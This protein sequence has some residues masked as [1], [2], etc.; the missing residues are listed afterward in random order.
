M[1]G[2]TGGIR[3]TR[4][5]PNGRAATTPMASSVP[6]PEAIVVTHWFDPGQDGEPYS[7]TIQL[8]GRRIGAHG[9]PKSS[10]TFTHEEALDRVVPGS[11]PVS[12]T[13]H[14]YGLL[15]GAWDIRA[16]LR[17]PP[18][19]TAGALSTHG[20]RRM[21]TESLPRAIWSWRRWAL[22]TASDGPVKTRWALAAPLARIPGVLPGSFTV[23][24]LLGIAVAV[25]V[26][27]AILERA[28]VSISQSILVSTIAILSGL[29][30]AK[31]WSRALHPGEAILGPGW[32][33]DGFVVVAP[34][35][36]VIALL[37]LGLPIGRFLDASAPGIFAAVAI[38]RFGCFFT[39]C[40]TGR[41]T[42]HRFGLWSSD[43]RIGARRIPTQLLESGA[44][45][46]IGLAAGLLVLGNVIAL[47]GAVFVASV[48]TYLVARQFLLRLR[49]EPRQFLWQRSRPV[50]LPGSSTST[51]SA[52]R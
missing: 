16:E 11:G 6:E 31:L 15:P 1:L 17:R 3:A 50:P 29:I 20:G 48:A 27:A 10:D 30:G 37:A 19:R 41:C 25:V 35:A 23:L 49:A 46:V 13:S 4:A 28:G 47:Q 21:T 38:G 8:S 32:A 18:T 43:R 42:R 52:T 44:G 26:P 36:A 22:S 39:G 24:G 2:G 7:A 12:V 33:V 34:T 45:L 14:V 9:R 5:D 40:C 51:R